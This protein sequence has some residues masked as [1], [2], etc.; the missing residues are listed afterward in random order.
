MLNLL[1]F[2]GKVFLFFQIFLFCELFLYLPV[3]RAEVNLDGTL[4]PQIALSGPDFQI[5]AE[6]GR[7]INNSNLFYSFG[8]FNIDTGQSATFTG[9]NSISNIVG[10]VTGGS[11]SNIDGLIK[12][13]LPAN[14]FLMNPYGFLFGPGARLD[15][16]GSFHVTTSDYISLGNKGI[17]YADPLKSS[18]LTV[19]PPGAFGFLNNNPAEIAVQDSWL[20]VPEKTALSLVGGDI[21]ITGTNS[22]PGV[23]APGGR[24][25]I[26]G[27]SSPGEVISNAPGETL[28]LITDSFVSLGNIDLY[29]GIINAGGDGGGTV[30]IRGGKLM[31][32]TS[33][34]YASTKGT[35]DADPGAGIDIEISDDMVVDNSAGTGSAIGTNVFGN[36]NQGSGGIRITADHLEIKNGAAIQS[37]AFKGSTGKSGD[38]ELNTNT[39]LVQNS[40]NI[41]AGTGGSEKSG[42][43]RINTS[44]LEI[45]DNGLVWTN[46]FDGTGDGG[47]IFVTADNI[48]LSNIKY[49]EKPTG[50]TTQTY[51]PGTGKSGDIKLDMKNLQMLP[52][53]QISSPSYY[54]GQSGNINMDIKETGTISGARGLDTGI[55]ANTF[56]SGTGG[57]IIV[58]ADRLKMDSH[59]YIMANA[60][61]TGHSGNITLDADTLEIKNASSISASGL[62]STGGAS[63]NVDI[64]AK[65]IVISGFEKTDDPF[66]FD[67]TGISTVS[68]KSGG[69]GGDIHIQAENIEMTNRG[70]ISANSFGPDESGNIKIT[71][72]KIA[73]LNG[74]AV[75]SGGYGSGD[76]GLLQIAATELRVSGVHPE[77][78]ISSISNEKTLAISAIG[79]QAGLLGGAGGDMIIQTQDLKIMDGGLLGTDSFGVGDAGDIDI[80][81]RTILISG[82]NSDWRN[83]IVESGGNPKDASS[84]ITSASSSAF[85]GDMATGDAGTITIKTNILLLE[86]KGSIFSETTTPGTGGNIDISTGNAF[87][88]S[89]ASISAMSRVSEQAGKA[90]NINI[91]AGETIKMDNTSLLTTSEQEQGGD[92]TIRAKSIDLTGNT[93]ISAQSEGKGNAGN[94]RV[95]GQYDFLMENS[96]LSTNAMQADGG[97]IKVFADYMVYL[98]DSEITACVGGGKETTGGNVSIDPRYVILK[99]STITANAFEGKGGNIEI[100]S[101]LFLADP[102]SIIDASSSLGIDGQVDIQSPITNVSGL[103]SPLSKDF[104]NV[105]ALLREPCL[106]RVQKGEYSS[107]MIKGRDSIP[108]GPERFLSSPL[109]LQ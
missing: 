36:V 73:V 86:E 28:D 18:L 95:E 89:G 53:T 64:T 4:G 103:I 99:N 104:K 19:D 2:T 34:I 35:C 65:D 75:T 107:F 29:N 13:D 74:S 102:D 93:R 3:S 55:F 72:T 31:V 58:N 49:P 80:D 25:N 62:R 14:L 91:A 15:I 45:Q 83:F 10:R 59:A 5:N 52:G 87:L 105:V 41:Q 78:F 84:H 70:L 8:K 71:A 100:I 54:L 88:S 38:I 92:I 43:I 85:L 60:F 9:P 44:N 48:F 20:E 6:Y 40:G 67:T 82:E 37:V 108:T 57:D 109:P 42:N 69:K 32:D 96:I 47:D 97:N 79:S 94:L 26:V 27:V 30:F 51:L 77:P 16:N 24:I 101:D 90:G 76:G 61:S 98:V 17:F 39:L 11:L 1:R 7:I 22:N 66:G 50:I 23:I 56:W 81:A 46:A 68:G 21:K 33:F 106:A 12:S 63:G